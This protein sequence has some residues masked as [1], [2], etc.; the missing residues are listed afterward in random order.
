M[1]WYQPVGHWQTVFV[2]ANE[3]AKL[4]VISLKWLIFCIICH[5]VFS[6]QERLACGKRSESC[7]NKLKMPSLT[8]KFIVFYYHIVKYEKRNKQKTGFVSIIK[9]KR[10]QCEEQW[11]PL[12]NWYVLVQ[13]NSQWLEDCW[14]WKKLLKLLSWA[15]MTYADVMHYICQ[16]YC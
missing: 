11:T 5:L 12:V 10:N 16:L 15:G 6:S 3:K 8:N 7:K 2:P 14:C 9:I 4:Y 13:P 1:V